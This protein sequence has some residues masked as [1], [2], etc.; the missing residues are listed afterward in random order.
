VSIAFGVLLIARPGSGAL[1]LVWI[2]A[3]FAIL[4][5]CMLA[6]LSFRLK[7]LRPA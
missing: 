2:M 6:A 7:Q 1:A 3:A 5:G 4:P